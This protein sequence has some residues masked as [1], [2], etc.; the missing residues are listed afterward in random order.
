MS[1]D[2]LVCRFRNH[3][4]GAVVLG[5]DIVVQVADDRRPLLLG[6]LVEV[7]DGDAGR[8]NGVVWVGDGHVGRSLGS[9]FNFQSAGEGAEMPKQLGTYKIIKLDSRHTTVHARDDL[10]GNGDGV[11]VVGVEAVTQSRD[12]SSDLVELDTL[13]ASIWG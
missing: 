2:A 7:G 5:V 3:G 1:H 13:L 4:R 10:L 6:L 11:D 9:L 12:T 8:E